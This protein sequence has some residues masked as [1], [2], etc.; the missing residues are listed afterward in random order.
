MPHSRSKPDIS[1]VIPTYNRAGL[2][3]ASLESLIDQTLDQDRYEVIVVDDGSTDT[4]GE[5]CESLA[6]KLPLRYLRLAE[7]S[8]ISAAKNLGLFSAQADIVLFFDDDDV[9][10]KKLLAE[11]IGSHHEHPEETAAILGY[12]E[13]DSKVPVTPVMNYIT[14]IG[15]MLFSYQSLRDGQELDFTFFWGGRSS[16][17]R[18]FLAKHGVFNPKFRFIYEDIELGYRLSKHGLKV[19]FN[20]QAVSTMVRPITFEQFCRRCERQGRAARLF[21]DIHPD[22]VVQKYCQRPDAREAWKFI[23]PRLDAKTARVHELETLCETIKPRDAGGDALIRSYRKELEDLYWWTFTAHRFKGLIEALDEDGVKPDEPAVSP[24]QVSAE[25]CQTY[26]A[27]WRGH[28]EKAEE[29]NVLVIDP[30]LPWFDR[31]SGSLRLMHILLSFRRL[32]YHVTLISSDS[33]YAEQYVPILRQHGIEVYAGDPAALEARGAAVIGPYLDVPRI[34]AARKYRIVVASFWESAEYYLPLIRQY[35]P[36]AHVAVDSVDVHYVRELREAELAG[37]PALTE[38]AERRKERELAVYRSADSAWVVTAQDRN[39]LEKESVGVPV[40]IVPNIHAT[41]QASKTYFDTSGLLFIGNFNHRPNI[42]GILYFIKEIFPYVLRDLPA[43][44]CTIVGNN[45][46]PELKSLESKNVEVLGHVPDIGPILAKARISICPLRYGAGM[47][48]KVGEALS[49]GIPVVTTTIGAEGMDLKDGEDALIADA[50]REFAKSIVK[51]Y[52]D[53]DLWEKLSL[54]GKKKVERCWSPDVISRQLADIL[55]RG[56]RSKELPAASIIIVT[57]NG[58]EFTRQCIE[59]IARNTTGAF[60]VIVVDNASTDDTPG[61]IAREAEKYPW[62]SLIRNQ[63]NRGFPAAC[64]Q[65]IA[66]AHG[67]YMILLNND[68][69]VTESWLEGLIACAESEPDIGIVGP[70]TN[71]ISGPQCDTA[72]RYSVDSIVE[73]ARKYRSDH[74]GEW[75]ESPRITGFCMLIKRGVVDAIGGLEPMFGVGN[76]EDDDYCVR[77]RLRGFRSVIAGDV[78]L[79]HFGG[80]SFRAQGE[81]VYRKTLDG[82]RNVFRLKWGKHAEEIWSGAEF[83]VRQ[84][85]FV[86]V[87]SDGVEEAYSRAIIAFREREYR[88]AL[89]FLALARRLVPYAAGGEGSVGEYDLTMRSGDCFLKLEM[90]QEAKEEY[91]HALRLCPASADACLNLGICFELAGMAGNAR[92]MY[93]CALTLKPGWE[94]AEEKIRGLG[95]PSPEIQV[96]Q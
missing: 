87:G 26:L 30:T 54:A 39:A 27:K 47:K 65:G 79:H 25:E 44:R 94:I 68:V 58:L 71:W 59:S 77:A 86:P 56:G 60:E 91:E 88:T 45:P 23:A 76:Y 34:L 43:I 89:E 61:Y 49:W 38:A 13:W 80:K 4:T 55:K 10:G 53:I 20:R 69:I 67:D 6:S 7:N 51:G 72:A 18:S 70:M 84:S 1:V 29:N 14:N 63:S 17:K 19:Y 50:P 78:F 32:G 48:G 33:R 46:P 83:P 92:T 24:G 90:L 74:K 82:N 96:A 37:D 31:A 8:G 66:R 11:H 93:T 73:F 22:P 16:C 36:A 57:Y 5:L 75:K 52:L 9:A 64:N 42:D 15:Q 62:L 41:V 81:D 40:E 2:L 3:R 35:A 21:S 12:T 95:E 85:P 28:S